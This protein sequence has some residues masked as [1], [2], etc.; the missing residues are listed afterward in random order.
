MNMLQLGP[1]FG[2]GDMILDD[3][4]LLSKGLAP[5]RMQA[6]QPETVSRFSSK[7]VG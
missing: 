4:G 2:I 6:A 3:F 1:E 5:I 7:P